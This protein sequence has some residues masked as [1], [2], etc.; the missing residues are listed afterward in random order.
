MSFC[1]HGLS[2]WTWEG[3]LTRCKQIHQTNAPDIEI[4]TSYA[5][6][7]LQVFDATEVQPNVFRF[8][9]YI[10]WLDT[11]PEAYGKYLHVKR[12]R[13]VLWTQCV[14]KLCQNY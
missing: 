10:L 5:P 9:T 2:E 13:P 3:L 6:D 7:A 8:V 1:Q 4:P 14:L 11:Q 12:N